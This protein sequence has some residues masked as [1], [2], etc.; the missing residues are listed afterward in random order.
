MMISVVDKEEKIAAA[1]ETI[2]PMLLDALIVLSDAEIIRLIHS[3]P[4]GAPP[5]AN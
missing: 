1:I 2:A 5:P 4:P 3:L